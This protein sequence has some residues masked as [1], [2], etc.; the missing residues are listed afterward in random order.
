MR[1]GLSP[2]LNYRKHHSF[3]D[4]FSPICT[5]NSI[6]SNVSSFET[7]FESLISVFNRVDD[8]DAKKHQQAF[9]CSNENAQVWAGP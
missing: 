5:K 7:V 3:N 6:F 2:T 8:Y 9:A 4:A 1:F